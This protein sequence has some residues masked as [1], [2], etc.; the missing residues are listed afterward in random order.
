[1]G[2]RGSC[3][4][5]RGHDGGLHIGEGAARPS[6]QTISPRYGFPWGEEG[7]EKSDPTNQS[8]GTASMVVVEGQEADDESRRVH[9]EPTLD[10]FLVRHP[11][12]ADP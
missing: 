11:R 12:A 6:T 4:R 8:V 2:G 10:F 3:R 7:G 1:M 5:V 9:L